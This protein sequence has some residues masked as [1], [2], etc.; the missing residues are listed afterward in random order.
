MNSLTRD[1]RVIYSTPLGSFETYEE[2]AAACERADLDSTECIEF[3]RPDFSEV[4]HEF[5]G[6]T[7]PIKLSFNVRVF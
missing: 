2:A 5:C 4:S 3:V 7:H 1:A 6:D